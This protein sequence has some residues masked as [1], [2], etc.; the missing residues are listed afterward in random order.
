ME[1]GSWATHAGGAAP[2]HGDPVGSHPYLH[3]DAASHSSNTGSLAPV[4]KG[5][6]ILLQ[7]RVQEGSGLVSLNGSGDE[8]SLVPKHG[9]PS[10]CNWVCRNERGMLAWWWFLGCWQGPCN[11]ITWTRAVQIKIASDGHELNCILTLGSQQIKVLS[12]KG[13]ALLFS[14]LCIRKLEAEKSVYS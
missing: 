12:L 2:M 6:R 1:E 14:R 11:K 8:E 3:P 10:G 7:N 9:L 13:E 5:D 4:K